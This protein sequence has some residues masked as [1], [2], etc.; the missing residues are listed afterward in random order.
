MPGRKLR[1]KTVKNAK[2][3]RRAAKPDCSFVV[4][5]PLSRLPPT[6]ETVEASSTLTVSLPLAVF[7]SAPVCSGSSLQARFNKLQALPVGW[8]QSA[9][10]DQP[11]CSSNHN[12]ALP[13][14]YLRFFFPFR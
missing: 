12:A 7:K 11:L 3:K 1:L 9:S 5:I 8:T 6:I 10:D 14:L 13:Y 2:R 4:S